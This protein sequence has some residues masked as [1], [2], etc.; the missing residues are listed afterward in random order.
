MTPDVLARNDADG[1]WVVG[2]PRMNRGLLAGVAASF[3]R[4][5]T[6]CTPGCTS[7]VSSLG[8][9]LRSQSACSK[10]AIWNRVRAEWAHRNRRI[11]PTIASRGNSY[12][13]DGA[14][15][16]AIATHSQTQPTDPWPPAPLNDSATPATYPRT[17]DQAFIGGAE[18]RRQWL[19]TLGLSLWGVAAGW[20]LGHSKDSPPAATS[21]PNP[22]VAT[23]DATQE[24]PLDTLDWLVGDWAAAD[25]QHGIEFSCHFTK[26]RAFLLR[27]F[28]ILDGNDVRLSGMQ[29]VGFDPAQKSLRSWTYDSQGG[30]GEEAWSQS[31]DRYTIRARYTLPDGGTGSNLQV[32]TF[33]NPDQFT[34]KSVNREIDGAFLPDSDE[35]VLVRRPASDDVKGDE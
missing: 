27:S 12:F 5:H 6:G 34:W 4:R 32:V 2:D 20:S 10:C 35:I 18:M 29:L 17:F 7:S 9:A 23:I 1:H 15:S 22:A 13:R 28:R 3:G 19:L 8:W 11:K 33:I 30:F 31:G 26:S 21:T 25:D 16:L 14:S 24:R